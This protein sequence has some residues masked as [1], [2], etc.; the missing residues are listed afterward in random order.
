MTL[1]SCGW[2]LADVRTTVQT[3]SD[4]LYIYTWAGYTDRD[5]LNKFQQET[6]IRVI[7]DVFSSNEEMLAKLQAGAGGAYSIIYPSDYMVI[8]M[9]ELG[10]LTELDRDRLV[11]L[12]Q[13]FPQFESP[14]YD[15]DNRYSLPVSWGTTGL[16]FNKEQLKPAPEDWNY[17]WDN[18]GQIYKRATL[19]N[20]AREV[21]GATL[22]M[23]GYSYNSTNPKEIQEAYEWLAELKPAISAFTSDA[24]RSQIVTGDLKI[25][26]GYSFDANEVMEESPDLQYV[27][28]KSGSSLW[29]DTLVIPSTA[30]NLEAAYAWMNFMLDPEIAASLCKR[31]GFAISSQAG[32]ELLP[33][34]IKDNPTLFP[35]EVALEKSQGLIPIPEVADL[36]DRYW[37]RLTSA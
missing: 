35:S 12:D 15:T 3:A 2:T 16:I 36:Y 25:A 4:V 5:L 13:L 10:L 28:P 26:M 30:P 14:S 33:P 32:F 1:S 6:G 17:L 22:R 7:A 11:G 19:L 37:T 18:Q 27:L 34:E 9:K 21:M 29:T 8:K 31:L 20:D 23:L 24:W